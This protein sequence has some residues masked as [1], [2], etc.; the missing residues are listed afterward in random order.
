[1][2]KLLNG[3]L[4]CWNYMDRNH[5]RLT[6]L[7]SFVALFASI[8]SPIIIQCNQSKKDE[9]EDNLIL[10]FSPTY[11]YIYVKPASDKQKLN[12]SQLYFSNEITEKH[13]DLQWDDLNGYSFSLGDVTDEIN[14][15]TDSIKCG[16]IEIPIIIKTKYNSRNR[17]IEDQSEYLLTVTKT[18]IYPCT[19][20]FIRNI[21]RRLSDKVEIKNEIKCHKNEL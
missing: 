20:E 2:K 3:W 10:R 13:I 14:K 8:L 18:L 1:M 5:N 7:V 12:V 4:W 19:I 9:M 17:N 16:L 11:G 15:I 6:F 21:T